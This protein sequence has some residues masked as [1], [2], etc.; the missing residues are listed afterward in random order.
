MLHL[1]QKIILKIRKFAIFERSFCRSYRKAKAAGDSGPGKQVLELYNLERDP[2]ERHNLATRRPEV[3]IRLRDL[4]LN[5][6]RSAATHQQPGLQAVTDVCFSE[7][8]FRHDSWD[9]RPQNMYVQFSLL[10]AKDNWKEQK[11]ICNLSQVLDSSSA[12]GG[13]S[14][15][16]RAVVDTRCRPGGA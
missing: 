2:G 11:S 12:F 14:G 15:W 3:V 1:I 16:C 7:N 4:A 6:Y 8:W 13:L 10:V 9:C 5:Y